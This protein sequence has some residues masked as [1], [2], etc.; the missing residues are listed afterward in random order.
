MPKTA[1]A[2]PPTTPPERLHSEIVARFREVCIL[3]RQGRHQAAAEILRRLLPDLV[4]RWAAT[5]TLGADQAKDHLRALFLAE[6]ERVEHGWIVSRFLSETPIGHRGDASVSLAR[7]AHRLAEGQADVSVA[8]AQ[9]ASERIPLH[10]VPGMI[11]Y[12]LERERLAR[13]RT[14]GTHPRRSSSL[15]VA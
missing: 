5:C 10:D 2:Q 13:R 11:D 6:Q 14:A 9:H 12:S 7:Y 1:P 4:R 8:P 15:Q 3:R